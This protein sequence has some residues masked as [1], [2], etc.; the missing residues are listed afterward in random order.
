MDYKTQAH[1]RPRVPLPLH[2][3]P[4][5]RGQHMRTNRQH[6]GATR[7]RPRPGHLP[8]TQFIYD[9]TGIFLINEQII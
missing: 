5:V 4:G 3:H 1:Q 9:E 6:G 7:P 2:R 8:N